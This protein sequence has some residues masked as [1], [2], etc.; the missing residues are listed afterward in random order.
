LRR[1]LQ[2]V[3]ERENL[4]QLQQSLN[5]AERQLSAK[6]SEI[7]RLEQTRQRLDDELSCTR[8]QLADR[9]QTIGRLTT[10]TWHSLL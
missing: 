7:V 6:A 4:M 10:A 3:H 5:S 1:V 9:N 8:D 2:L